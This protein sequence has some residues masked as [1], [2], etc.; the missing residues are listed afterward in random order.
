MERDMF[1]LSSSSKKV[2]FNPSNLSI[3]TYLP[4]R[5]YRGKVEEWKGKSERCSNITV[6]RETYKSLLH[7]GYTK[8][9]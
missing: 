1:T 6:L 2:S 9:W 7:Q 8:G 4:S 5:I 3:I